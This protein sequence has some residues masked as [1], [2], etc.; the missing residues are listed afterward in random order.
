[1]QVLRTYVRVYATNLD[2]VVPIVSRVA[3]QP[4]C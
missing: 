2:D 1:M 4:E 3:A